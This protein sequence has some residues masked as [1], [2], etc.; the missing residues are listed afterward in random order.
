MDRRL[1]LHQI[2]LDIMDGV[3]QVYFQ[4]TEN[5]KMQYPA[6]VYKRDYSDTQFAGNKPYAVERR[7]QITYIDRNPDSTI[8]EE[9]MQLP[10]C[11]HNR[12]FVADN[13][14]H[15]VFSLYY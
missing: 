7:Y 9:I 2:L 1:Q 12:H 8:V 5:T 10:K 11:L 15:D 4:P 6:I 13:L 14:N 3:H